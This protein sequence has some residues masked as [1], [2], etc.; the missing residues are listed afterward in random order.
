MQKLKRVT[1]LVILLLSGFLGAGFLLP[2]VWQVERQVWIHAPPAAVFPYLNNLRKWRDWTVWYRHDPPPSTEYSGPDQGVGATSRWTDADTHGVMKIMESKPD[3]LV[4]YTLLLGGGEF[5]LSGSLT[6]Q[7]EENGTRVI[8][9][10]GSETGNNPLDRYFG[11]IVKFRVG[12]D[13][14]RSLALLR[15][16]LE[17]PAVVK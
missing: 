13:V 1:L 8:W 9:R 6:L 5:A 3:R 10:A 7:P 11:A 12:R 4:D 14:D 2:T 17:T 16:K 15:E